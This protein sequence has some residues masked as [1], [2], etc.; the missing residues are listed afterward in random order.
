LLTDASTSVTTTMV[1]R[2]WGHADGVMQS[3]DMHNR[4][5]EK[6]NDFETSGILN[7]PKANGQKPKQTVAESI[8]NNF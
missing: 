2:P 3:M 7:L 6:P 8:S 5:G 4:H 1:C